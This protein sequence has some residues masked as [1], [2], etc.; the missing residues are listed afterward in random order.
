MADTFTALLRLVLQET[1]GN[2]NVWGDINN[3]SAV[4]LL[5]DA[6][7]AISNIDVTAGNV[8]LTPANGAVDD[9]RSMFLVASGNPGV[10]R[11]IQVPST[12]KLYIVSNETSPGFDVTIKTAAGSGVVISPATTVAVRV[13]PV[14]DDVFAIGDIPLATETVA[15]VAE[16]ATQAET[17]A[18]ALD[19]K[20]VTP[21]K[22]SLATSLPQAT[23]TVK[24]AAEIATQ[25][26]TDAGVLDDK[27]VSPLK[28]EG[29]VATESLTGIAAIADQTEVDAGT[30]DTKFVT[31]LKLATTPQ[32]L[33]GV[34]GAK[35]FGSANQSI[36]TGPGLTAVAL[37]S[38][39]YD[40]GTPAI[41]DNV[42]NNSRFTVPT[43]ITRIRLTGYV[44]WQ[45]NGS[46]F[47]IL[48]ITKNGAL[49]TIDD[50]QGGYEPDIYTS[51]ANASV[52]DVGVIIDSGIIRAVA[53]DYFELEV[54]QESG[55]ALN[56]LA[57][58]YWFQMD[59]IE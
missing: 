15:G 34:R 8:V 2:Q 27:I 39:A 46:S 20:I 5:E 28:L 24:G 49:G 11:Q 9:A 12:S 35:A 40:T 52:P 14:A 42:I 22:L 59:L 26:E 17:D 13:D 56:L 33:P 47:R 50:D 18:G 16:I 36:P 55:V 45:P 54:S 3:A 58:D 10:A 6:I 23:E 38:E 43:G 53:T 21:L 37:A 51:A 1:G 32:A 48:K 4:D 30:N 29:R 25:V 41:H 7:A 44:K 31:P 57:G 19:D